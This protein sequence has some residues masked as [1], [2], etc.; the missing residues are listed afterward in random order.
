MSELLK[1]DIKNLAVDKKTVE[2]LYNE[3]ISTYKDLC[4]HSRMELGDKGLSNSQINN[5]IISLQLNGLDLKP[6]HAK[7]NL[8]LNHNM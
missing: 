6:N 2:V 8:L 5:I 3:G 7:K 1:K 4:S